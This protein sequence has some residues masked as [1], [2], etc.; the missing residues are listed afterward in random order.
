MMMW[1][2]LLQELDRCLQFVDATWDGSLT[3]ETVE[4]QHSWVCIGFD[5]SK[6]DLVSD[7]I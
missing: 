7:E 5:P 1:T 6:T 4:A 3:N 2:A